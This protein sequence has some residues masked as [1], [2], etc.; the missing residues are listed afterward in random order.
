MDHNCA[1]GIWE[2]PLGA[3]IR[4]GLITNDNRIR[5]LLWIQISKDGSLYLGARKPD[6]ESQ[7]LGAKPIEGRESFIGYDEGEPIQDEAASKNPKLSFHASGVVH[8]AGKMWFRNTIRDLRERQL[9]CQILFQHPST[10]SCL[11]KVKK[12][13][14]GLWYPVDD[15]YPI[16]C[17]NSRC[18]VS[19]VHCPRM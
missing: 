14:I 5:A 8:A 4:I 16:S 7:K 6:L 19:V 3:R 18:Q 17:S 15:E 12:H 11:E 2:A 9:I 1:I 13:D 10:F